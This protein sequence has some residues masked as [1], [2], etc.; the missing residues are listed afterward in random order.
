MQHLSMHGVRN[1]VDVYAEEVS[2]RGPN[3]WRALKRELQEPTSSKSVCAHH[4]NAHCINVAQIND[5]IY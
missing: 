3:V 1:S 4:N 5:N 2:S